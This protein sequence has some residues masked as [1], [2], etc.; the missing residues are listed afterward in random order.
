MT[1]IA[2]DTRTAIETPENVTLVFEL[3]GPGAR[4]G[5][6]LVDLILRVVTG[7]GLLWTLSF[8]FPLLGPGMPMG[9]FLVCWFLLEWGYGALFEG[10]WR[11]RTPG[12]KFFHLRVIKDVGSPIGFYDA[13]LRNLLRAADILPIGYGVGLICMMA[14]RNL[15]RVGDLVAG[16][17]VVRS[18]LH[19]FERNTSAFDRL[20][21]I[22]PGEC[23]GQFSVSERT[24]DVIE[25]LVWRRDN[26]PQRRVEE[27]AGLLAV[28]IASRLGYNLD[29]KGGS[30]RNIYFLR[31]V[32]RT[33]S[34]L[35]ENEPR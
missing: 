16:T 22:P 25:Q 34:T 26:L 9:V 3:A 11:G 27:V 18:D 14:T 10:L 1:T 4:M 31:R 28:P 6:Y 30:A 8:A 12:K 15:Q 35:N 21:P 2:I 17:I 5:A 19:R 20:E 29:E 23:A 33:F 7:M 13:T 32:L 24:L